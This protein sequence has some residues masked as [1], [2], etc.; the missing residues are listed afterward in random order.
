MSICWKKKSHNIEIKRANSLKSLEILKMSKSPATHICE[1]AA[2]F[3]LPATHQPLTFDGNVRVHGWGDR[4]EITATHICE[5]ATHFQ[6]PAA[7]N[8]CTFHPSIRNRSTIMGTVHVPLQR[9]PHS[10]LLSTQP[11]FRLRRLVWIVITPLL[12]LLYTCFVEESLL[13]TVL[14]NKSRT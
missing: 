1:P 11:A 14:A 4:Q 7:H 5:P 10:K 3:V 8:P 13:F 9:S 2:H 12:M 6:Q